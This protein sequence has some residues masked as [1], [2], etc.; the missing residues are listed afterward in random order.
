[1][2]ELGQRRS[3][4]VTRAETKGLSFGHYELALSE[5]I[6]AFN[7][8]FG[9]AIVSLVYLALCAAL[10]LGL[11]S[12]ILADIWRLTIAVVV[13]LLGSLGV[14]SIT[15]R[16]KMRI[17]PCWMSSTKRLRHCLG[18]RVF[19]E[20]QMPKE[21]RRGLMQ[22]AAQI[23][24]EECHLS[25]PDDGLILETVRE[26]LA[27]AREGNF[28]IGAVIVDPNGEIICSGHNQVFHPRFRSDG[29][30]EMV[31]MSRFE[32]MHPQIR[33]FMVTGSTRR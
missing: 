20:V 3:R 25:E 18:G 14:F 26:A 22:L 32:E 7:T 29:H 17:S 33:A 1:M 13:L 21:Q 5:F 4:I 2:L 16:R 27:A 28:G 30:A 10:K 19:Q 12:G 9:L 23:Q 6:A 8:S 24:S 11:V 15:Q 31:V